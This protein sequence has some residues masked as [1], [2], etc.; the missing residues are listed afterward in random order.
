VEK[1]PG[2]PDK[3]ATDNFLLRVTK[4][5]SAN[6]GPRIAEASLT[7]YA[8]SFSNAAAGSKIS[9]LAITGQ[10][11][12]LNPNVTYSDC[13]VKMGA[14]P[15]PGTTYL[16]IKANNASLATGLRFEHCEIRPSVNSV[17]HYGIQGR[18]FTLYRCEITGVVDGVVAHGTSTFMGAVSLQG[19]FIH[20]LRHFKND[21]RQT[22][23]PEGDSHD[24]G[25]QIEGK[26]DIEIIGNTIWGGYTSAILVT[27][28]VGTYERVAIEDNWLDQENPIGGSVV[29]ISE[30]GLGPINN[31]SL[32][33]N[34]FGRTGTG[35]RI[36]MPS[37][38]RLAATSN[39]PTSGPD[40]NVYEDNGAFVS[41]TNG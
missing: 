2:L 40:A 7:N 18:G 19:N 11:N 20:D 4:P 5:T 29:N 8:G 38:T 9:G 37:T 10:I 23:E 3:A 21:P 6:T 14:N 31:L 36:I 25:G 35:F 17:D 1:R 16:G 13:L 30:K 27:Q 39:I 12:A 15:N 33:R 28:N 34:K 32:I 26:L 24:D 22:T 41:I